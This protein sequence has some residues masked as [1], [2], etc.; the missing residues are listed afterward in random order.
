[1]LSLHAPTAVGSILARKSPH[2][3]SR[4]PL[5]SGIPNESKYFPTSSI[6]QLLKFV[7]SAS[8]SNDYFP[9]GKNLR[10]DAALPLWLS[11]P[12]SSLEQFLGR[13][14]LQ[15]STVDL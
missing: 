4:P 1:M 8:D 2:V 15:K 7:P 10:E 3:N 11:S 13:I 9:F 5:Y 14:Q 6:R 12:M